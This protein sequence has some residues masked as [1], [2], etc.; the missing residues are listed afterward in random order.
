MSRHA[1]LRYPALD[2]VPTALRSLFHC[3]ISVRVPWITWGHKALWN[4]VG[5]LCGAEADKPDASPEANPRTTPS[6]EGTSWF[7]GEE[8]PWEELTLN[9]VGCGKPGYLTLWMY[10]CIPHETTWGH[11]E[12]HHTLK[13]C[14]IMP[15][16]LLMSTNPAIISSGTCH[17]QT[18]HVSTQE[19]QDVAISK[20]CFKKRNTSQCWSH[21]VNSGPCPTLQV[22]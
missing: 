11:S 4:S 1:V 7:G 5:G 13:T 22:S 3:V 21:K 19:K 2:G 18:L 10:L 9:V 14:S 8:C 16:K 20:S 6:L 15:P 12:G 17:A